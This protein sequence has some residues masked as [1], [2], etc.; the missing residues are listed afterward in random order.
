MQLTT[1]PD[2]A[3]KLNVS[4]QTIT[5]NADNHGIGQKHG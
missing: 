2:L 5:R 3:S 4:P 1:A